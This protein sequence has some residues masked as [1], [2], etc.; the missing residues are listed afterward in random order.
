MLTFSAQN[1]LAAVA[2]EQDPND[3]ISYT[4][5]YQNDLFYQTD[6][7]NFKGYDIEVVEKMT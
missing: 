7:I 5:A 1:N 4:Q 3:S 2:A 6:K